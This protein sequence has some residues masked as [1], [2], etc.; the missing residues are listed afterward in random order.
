M[1]GIC[2]IYTKSNLGICLAYELNIPCVR[3][4]SKINLAVQQPW[5]LAPACA[6]APSVGCNMEKAKADS[7]GVGGAL[8]ALCLE[9]TL[10]S[11]LPPC[12][13]CALSSKSRLTLS[14]LRRSRLLHIEKN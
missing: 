4:M 14:V 13:V 12:S 7:D 5:P 6:A 1:P 11:P 3:H 2:D 10:S 8:M 9:Q